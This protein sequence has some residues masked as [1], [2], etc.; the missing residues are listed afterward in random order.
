MSNTFKVSGSS[1]T[2]GGGMTSIYTTPSSTATTVLSLTVCNTHTAAITATVSL[3]K[4]GSTEFKICNQMSVAANATLTAI[5]DG[6]KLVLQA[7]DVLKVQTFVGPCDAVLSY[8][9]VA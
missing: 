1:L 9:E 6:Q 4:N 2:T 7:G 5:G 3:F 8:I